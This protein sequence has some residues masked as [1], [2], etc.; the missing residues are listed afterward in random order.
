MYTASRFLALRFGVWVLKGRAGFGRSTGFTRAYM[1]PPVGNTRL[2]ACFEREIKPSKKAW[3]L[4]ASRSSVWAG[5]N[6]M[7]QQLWHLTNRNIGQSKSRS[8]DSHKRQMQ[9]NQADPPPPARP[10]PILF[11]GFLIIVVV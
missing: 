11:W 4:A 9:R 2:L 6:K 8:V 7:L 1:Y 5:A 10:R 3:L